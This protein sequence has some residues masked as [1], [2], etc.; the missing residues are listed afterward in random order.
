[1]QNIDLGS[2]PKRSERVQWQ[3]FG[4]EAILLNP[5]SGDYVQISESGVEIWKHIDGH[6]S[7]QDIATELATH[8]D[9]APEH[10]ID[11]TSEF[12]QQL[13]LKDFLR[14]HCDR[15]EPNDAQ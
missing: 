1:M 12:V 4:S 6:R 9:G 8:F 11:H 2:I 5:I 15:C 7:V 10:L 3:E 13:V 14:L